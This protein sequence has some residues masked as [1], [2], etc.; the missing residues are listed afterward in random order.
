[1][2]F[3]FGWRKNQASI[4]AARSLLQQTAFKWLQQGCLLAAAKIQEKK[5]NLRSC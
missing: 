4:A 2:L 3:N 5:L 1:V